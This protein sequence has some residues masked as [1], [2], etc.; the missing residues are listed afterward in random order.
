MNEKRETSFYISKQRFCFVSWSLSTLSS[1]RKSTPL[2]SL[3]SSNVP[4]PQRRLHQAA[5]FCLLHRRV[6]RRDR[7][8]RGPLGRFR[9][10]PAQHQLVQHVVRAVE[11]EDEV[12]LADLAEVAVERFDVQVD[13]LQGGQ[14]VVAGVYGGREV[15]GGVAAV[16]DL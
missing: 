5:R 14:L 3:S 12:Q 2:P 7:P 10:V 15:E 8:H 11:L 16:D 1:H 6:L 9:H 13:G 4:R